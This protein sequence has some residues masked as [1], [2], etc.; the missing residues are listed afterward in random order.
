[1]E[2]VCTFGSGSIF[3]VATAGADWTLSAA[4]VVVALAGV[5]LA[6]ATVGAGFGV[7]AKAATADVGG[8]MLAF[9]F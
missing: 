2:R 5:V 7:A 3:V 9:A 1:V 8:H 6:K 4:P